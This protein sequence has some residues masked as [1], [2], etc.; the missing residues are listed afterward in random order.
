M[1]LTG[2]CQCGAV[3]HE[4]AAEP[5][6]IYVCHCHECQHQS[7][8]AF[9]ISVIVPTH[10]FVLRRGEVRTWCRQTDRG[11]TLECT[12]CAQCGSRVCH[13]TPVTRR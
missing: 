3:R 2:G 12:F 4:V 1:S 7:A 11:R 5:V 9:G 8:S 6:A 13:A 10:A